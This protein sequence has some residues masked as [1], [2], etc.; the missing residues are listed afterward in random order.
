MCIRDRAKDG[1]FLAVAVENERDEAVND[2]ALPQMPVGY[3]VKLPLKD[4]VMDC[5]G[6][7]KIEL[8]GLANVC[9]LYTSR[10]V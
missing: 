10:C 9:L 8:A 5:A 2:G 6:L 1:S 4:G 3:V 7:Q